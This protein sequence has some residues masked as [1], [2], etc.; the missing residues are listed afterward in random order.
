[1]SSNNLKEKTAK[2]VIW[3]TVDRFSA[4]GIQFVLS[5]FIAR[6]LMPSDYGL[7]AM[8]SIFMA[9]AQLFIDSGFSSALIQKQGRTETGY[10][11]VFYFNIVVGIAMYFLM[12][13]IAPFIS[14]FYEQPILTELIVFVALN[15]IVSSL[16]T[17]QRAQLTINLDFKRQA[18]ITTASVVVSGLVAVYMAFNGYGVRTL[19]AQSLLNNIVTVAL[20]WLTSRWHP[21]MVFSMKSF[22]ELFGF[23]SKLLTGGILQAIYANLYSL[24]IGKVFS[25][26]ELGLYSRANHTSN[27]LSTNITQVLVRVTYPVDV[28]CK[29]M[30]MN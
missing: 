19:V 21:S 12:Q 20:L 28:N 8:L 3:S 27:I 17:V 23:G 14:A 26:T 9:I 16:G 5:F 13:A 1:M 30:I 11:T 15:F 4:Q 18:Y 10:S 29:T 6:Q 7:I 22:K 25:T 2:D 24:I